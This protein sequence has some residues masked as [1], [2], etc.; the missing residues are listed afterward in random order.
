MNAQELL[1]LAKGEEHGPEGHIQDAG[2][3]LRLCGHSKRRGRHK[4]GGTVSL[5]K[6]KR[7]IMVK[8]ARAQMIRFNRNGMARTQD[9]VMYDPS[10]SM[11]IPGRAKVRGSGAWKWTLESL[12]RTAFA[13]PDR[14]TRSV[15]EGHG[16]SPASVIS[17]RFVVARC[18]CRGQSRAANRLAAVSKQPGC[19]LPFF[20][21][22]N[23]FDETQL[24]VLC[25]SL[26]ERS[27]FARHSQI[28]W[29]SPGGAIQDMDIV[30]PPRVLS[31]Y[32]A[33]VCWAALTGEEDVA[34]ILPNTT[35]KPV[36]EFYGTL[37]SMDSHSVNKR[38]VKYLLAKLP[39]GSFHLATF[40]LQHKTGHVMEA[41]TKRLGLI[42][43]CFCIAKQ[44]HHGGMFDSMKNRLRVIVQEEL[45]VLKP[46][47]VGATDLN[48]EF[49]KALL[50]QCFVHSYE[51]D[52]V[53]GPG[54]AVSDQVRARQ[55]IADKFVDFFPT[56]WQGTGPA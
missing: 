42:G 43:P 16:G 53:E 34:S 37:T 5:S 28:T 21:T 51:D 27:V 17:S 9:Y 40:C 15:I 47:D 36:A 3:L 4:T 39:P 7:G 2:V 56:L 44:F 32:T 12:C 10:Q 23:M 6:K 54:H 11:V 38:V 13:A 29:Q 46:G 8:Q 1:E 26:L 55:E 20:I 14:S 24:E 31:R 50:K 49:G 35:V 30:Q 18:I 19:K 48:K 45:Q 52:E 22:N 25:P 41:V 33:D